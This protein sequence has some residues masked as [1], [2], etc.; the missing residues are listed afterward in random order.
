MH[1]YLSESCSRTTILPSFPDLLLRS[2]PFFVLDFFI[3][4]RTIFLNANSSFS[5]LNTFFPVKFKYIFFSSF[6]SHAFYHLNPISIQM[7][8]G[9]ASAR[10]QFRFD[11]HGKGK[12]GMK[13]FS[14]IFE[15][16]KN[17][18]KHFPIKNH[19]KFNPVLCTRIH[20]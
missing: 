17:L 5:P 7:Y 12:D 16:I 11:G 13:R 10:S 8:D 14:I 1:K 18:G 2:L 3:S 4:F 15:S 9:G 6:F 19:S 20:I